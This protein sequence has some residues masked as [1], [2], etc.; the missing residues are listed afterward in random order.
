MY[1]LPEFN[2]KQ[3]DAPE[4]NIPKKK[5]NFP[6][7][8]ILI[9]IVGLVAGLYLGSTNAFEKLENK[10]DNILPINNLLGN[11]TQDIKPYVAQTTQEEKVIK[12]VKDAAPSVVSVIITKD[13]PVYKDVT[14]SP[15]DYFDPF[16]FFNPVP[17]RVQ[18]GT[19][20]QE[21]G[22]GSGFIVSD[23]GLVLTNKH[24]VSDNSAQYTIVTNDGKEYE[25]KVLAQDPVQDLAI[26]KIQ[27]TTDTFKPL[28]LGSASTI[29]LGQ[30]AI[31][32]GNAL[33]QFPNTVSV[34]VISGLSR[35][36]TATSD[37]GAPE[38][39]EGV[40]Q[41]DAAINP[42]NSGGPLLNLNGE[43][44]AINTAI[45][46]SGQNVGFAI[47]IDKAIRDIKQVE[48]TG[49]ISYPFLGIRY[50]SIDAGVAKQKNLSV[51]YGVLISGDATTNTP[52]ITANS[53]AAKA[54]LKENDIILEAG[55]QKI[56]ANNTLSQI[57]SN[58][59]PG[60]T[61]NLLVL[62][63]G[64]QITINVILGEWAPAQ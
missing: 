23:D 30:S 45:S 61:F 41:T 1:Q 37:T 53:P 43:V 32:I 7:V 19:Q 22:A 51:D 21:V 34:G 63:N 11:N 56:T 29:Q 8:G 2:L 17:Q 39:L 25:T 44:I 31:A 58:Y 24:V 10:T 57:I 42:G 3:I 36:I 62:R 49:K 48:A 47:T 9:L 28:K 59:N 38:T 20:K 64:S 12:V 6:I 54:G 14:P 50:I 4:N 46:S 40:I 13:V 55:G 35:T 16:G 60:Q 18:T 27:N 5:S 33:G 26:L 52:A 15:Q